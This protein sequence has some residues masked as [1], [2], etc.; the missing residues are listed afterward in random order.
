MPQEATTSST[1]ANATTTG[2]S[3][4]S[5]GAATVGGGG[6]APVAGGGGAAAT[7]NEVSHVLATSSE[8][9]RLVA[10]SVGINNLTEESCRE[11]ASDLTFTLRSILTVRIVVNLN[12][13][14]V[15]YTQK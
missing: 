11:L 10:E 8:S 7:A 3:S 2:S 12:V 1:A 5:S 15:L 6:S 13:G 4:S 9:I 14:H